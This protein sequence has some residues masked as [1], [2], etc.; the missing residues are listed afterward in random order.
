[1]N[2]IYQHLLQISGLLMMVIQVLGIY[3]KS[4]NAKMEFFLTSQRLLA[5]IRDRFQQCFLSS[6]KLLEHLS[7]C[8]SMYIGHKRQFV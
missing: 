1:M 6:R 5:T 3:S 7:L 8:S 4:S 2:A